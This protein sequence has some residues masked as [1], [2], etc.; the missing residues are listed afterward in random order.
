M[1][2][3]RLRY[4]WPPNW[5]ARSSACLPSRTRR[6]VAHSDGPWASKKLWAKEYGSALSTRL[7][8][9][10]RSRLTFFERWRPASTKPR[11]VSHWPSWAPC[12][13]ST[14]NSRN[15]MPS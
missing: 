9:P 3:T 8:S 15:S 4:G 6:A 1:G 5:L 14:A 2:P 11:R 10:W 13:S 12:A 7:M